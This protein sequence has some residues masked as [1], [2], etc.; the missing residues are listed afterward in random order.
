MIEIGKLAAEPAAANVTD[1]VARIAGRPPQPLRD[2]IR[3]HAAVF[4]APAP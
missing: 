3:G 4:A 1:A 2:F